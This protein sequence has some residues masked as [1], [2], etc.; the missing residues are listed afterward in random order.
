MER[1][2]LSVLFLPR[3]LGHLNFK[4]CIDVLG[5]SKG[6]GKG[7]VV[8]TAVVDLRGCGA[9]VQTGRKREKRVAVAHP[10]DL[11]TSIR[12]HGG[13]SVVMYVPACLDCI[14]K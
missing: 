13:K 10:N 14:R 4:L 8:Y 9:T 5:P 3:Q 2:D 6:K 11:A 12:P 1:L 7:T